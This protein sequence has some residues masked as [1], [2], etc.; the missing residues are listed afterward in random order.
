MST[1]CMFIFVKIILKLIPKLVSEKILKMRANKIIYPA[2]ILHV[3]LHVC[4]VLKVIDFDKEVKN[5]N[6]SFYGSF[7]N[8]VT[9]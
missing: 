7:I 2:K 1:F 5:R 9:L 4:I 3:I 6:L 8:Y